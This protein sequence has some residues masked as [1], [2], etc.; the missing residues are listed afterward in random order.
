MKK[1]V[2]AKDL[3]N[4]FKARNFTILTFDQFIILHRAVMAYPEAFTTEDPVAKELLDFGYLREGL[5]KS[6]YL[7]TEKGIHNILPKNIKD[8]I[9]QE[10]MQ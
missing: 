4:S 7:P 8:E 3:L 5:G 9:K 2:T 10:T 6:K 1:E